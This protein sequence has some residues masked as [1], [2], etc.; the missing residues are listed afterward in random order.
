MPHST[1]FEQTPIDRVRDFWNRRPCNLRHSPE[2][3]GT[4]AYFDQ[5][6]DRKYRVEPH[7]PAFA[8]FPRWAGKR[9]LEIGCGIGTDTVSFASAGAHVTAVDLSEKSIELARQRVELYGLSDRV[10]FLHANAEQLADHLPGETFDLVYSFGVIHHTPHPQRVMT[11]V[12]K[13]TA[14]GST[15]KIMVYHRYASKVFWIML[16]QGYGRFWKLDDLV[17]RHSE[18]QTGC[19]VT[20]SYT[21]QAA[22]ELVE[23]PG[24]HATDVF[25]DHI[26]PYRIPDYTQYRYVREWYYRWMPAWMFCAMERTLGWHVCVTAEA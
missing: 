3:V 25:V 12:R 1:V 10:R 5:V 19:P 2:P 4:R 6:R 8:E 11:Q 20:Y 26:F 22:K 24:F 18:A 15:V 9:V 17:A 21:R 7:I 13:L 23:S 16:T 14:P